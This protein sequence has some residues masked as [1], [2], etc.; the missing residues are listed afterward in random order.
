MRDGDT[1]LTNPEHVE[2]SLRDWY[3]LVDLSEKYPDILDTRIDFKDRL[4]TAD[5]TSL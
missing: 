2:G 1:D 3:Y 4:R 5:L